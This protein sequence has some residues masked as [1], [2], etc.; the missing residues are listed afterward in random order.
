[1]RIGKLEPSD[2]QTMAMLLLLV[3]SFG[4]VAARRYHR[5]WRDEYRVLMDLQQLSVHD[6]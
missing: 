1:M 5:L 3:N 4:I 6:P 2:A